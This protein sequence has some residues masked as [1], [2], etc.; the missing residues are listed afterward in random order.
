MHAKRKGEELE[1]TIDTPEGH[2][3]FYR[4]TLKRT[5]CTN[6]TPFGK[7]KDREQLC[8]EEQEERPKQ[9]T[10]KE[11]DIVEARSQD[12]IAASEKV[13]KAQELLRKSRRTK[14]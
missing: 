7:K 8:A 10:P 3:F 2:L 12:E 13:Q 11:V 9:Y 6:A 14:R 4:V 5:L 1:G